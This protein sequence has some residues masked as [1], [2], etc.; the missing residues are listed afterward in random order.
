MTANN[1]IYYR[2]DRC[3]ACGS[4]LKPWLSMVRDRVYGVDGDWNLHR[5]TDERCACGY[6]DARLTPEQLRAFYAT[7]STHS[8]PVLNASG[9]KRMFRQA[10]EWALHRGLGYPCPDVPALAKFL[11]M[12]LRVIPWFR[13]AAYSRVFWLPHRLSAKL[14]EI[15][16]G[17]AQTLLQLS[18]LG[19]KVEGIEFDSVCITKARKLGLQVGEGD[20]FAQDYADCSIDAVVGSHVIEHV[21]EPGKLI[22]EIYTKL[23][24]RGQLV[25][26]T[27]N[28]KSLG[29]SIFGRHWRGLEVPRHLTIQTPGSLVSYAE[30]AGFRKVQLFGT[31]RGGGILQQ[32]S[33]IRRANHTSPTGW[34][35]QLGWALIASVINAVAPRR[36]EEIVL[37]CEK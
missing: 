19:W 11:G 15:G 2:P 24:P 21:P 1:L 9:A 18:G 6:L 7:Y 3:G 8:A 16:F 35:A 28:G 36:S 31:P 30:Q 33:Q 13:H 22:A 23:A 25:L 34:A 20:F 17:N 5:C 27:P 26:V 12:V 10:I 4:S 32:S 14:L 29:S 37:F